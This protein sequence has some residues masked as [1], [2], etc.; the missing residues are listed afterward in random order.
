MGFPRWM[1]GRQAQS[2]LFT[3]PT[4]SLSMVVVQCNMF[5]QC[6]KHKGRT[7]KYYKEGHD[8]RS[9][10]YVYQSVNRVGVSVKNR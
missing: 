10:R 8:R 4:V 1:A 9:W 7:A 3:R 2:W 6:E 5:L